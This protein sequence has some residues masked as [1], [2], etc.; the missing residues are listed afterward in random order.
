[1]ETIEQILRESKQ[2]DDVRALLGDTYNNLETNA[3][4]TN[5]AIVLT[6]CLSA[7]VASVEHPMPIQ[8]SV[9]VAIGLIPPEAAL[10]AA[11]DVRG[12]SHAVSATRH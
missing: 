3:E 12:S 7:I 9:A 5:L 4:A 10:S 2:F 11:M 6:E 8:M 1:M